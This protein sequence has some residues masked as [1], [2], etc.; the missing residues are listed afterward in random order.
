MMVACGCSIPAQGISAPS[1]SPREDSSRT[2]SA[3]G[4]L[5]GLD[6]HNGHA[7]VTLSLPR[8]SFAGLQLDEALKR[9][10]AEPWCGVQIID[11]KSGDV[12]HWIR[13]DGEIREL[14]D[15]RVLPG[16]LKPASTGIVSGEIQ[17]VITVEG[18]L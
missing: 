10:D 7:I 11:L 12:V 1:I 4:F 3:P 14:F 16:I 18:E 8:H 15:I 5:R 13:I 17:S 9:R 6:F 2:P